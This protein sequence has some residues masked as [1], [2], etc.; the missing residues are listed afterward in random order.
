MI[1]VEKIHLIVKNTCPQVDV[2]KIAPDTRL[3]EYGIDSMDFFNII[4]ELQEELGK[5]IPD[6]DIDQLRT[7]ASIL[8]YFKRNAG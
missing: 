4:L 6:E 1:T 8:D 5:E 3:R 7:V 2:E